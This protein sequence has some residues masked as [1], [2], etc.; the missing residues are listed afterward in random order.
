MKRL[1][2]LFAVIA[3]AVILAIGGSGLLPA[4]HAQAIQDKNFRA[5]TLLASSTKTATGTSTAVC[6]LGVYTKYG[7]QIAVSA[8]SGTS[9]TLDVIVQHSID[10][11]TTWFT[12]ATF[13]QKTTTG[14]EL[15]I[16]SEVE[17][18]TAEVYGDCQRL[19]YTIGGTS[20]SFTFSVKGFAE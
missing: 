1:A 2:S 20:P 7:L 9:P 16:E 11:G 8:A 13:T 17:A 15:K 4:S 12:L 14:N 6:G 3:L 19:S 5:Y 10:G 18:A